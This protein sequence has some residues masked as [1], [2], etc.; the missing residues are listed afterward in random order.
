MVLVEERLFARQVL[1]EQTLQLIVRRVV[2]R[3]AQPR[4]DPPRVRVDHKDRLARRV[5]DDRV[6]GFGTDAVDREQFRAQCRGVEAEQ[7]RQTAAMFREQIARERFQLLRLEVEIAGR[8][9]QTREARGGRAVHPRRVQ[10]PRALEIRDC[11][12]DI[13]P[14]GVLRQDRA[15]DDFECA[16]AGPP[17][18]R[19]EARVQPRVD[20][21]ESIFHR[22]GL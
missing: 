9:N 15:D 22:G 7:A 18:L 11:L 2:A 14:R 19:A 5:Q 10:Q 20:V 13:R 16:V 4:H 6:G 17:V 3:Q 1:H 8:A 21:S 12:L